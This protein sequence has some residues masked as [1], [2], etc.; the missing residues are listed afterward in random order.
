MRSSNSDRKKPF[1]QQLPLVWRMIFSYSLLV[2]IL[3]ILVLGYLLFYQLK[4]RNEQIEMQIEQL[5][6]ALAENDSII[7]GLEMNDLDSVTVSMLDTLYRNLTYVDYI[8]IVNSD[9]IRIYHSEKDRI[10][11]SFA[12]GDEGPAL[13]GDSPS[14]VTHGKGSRQ[15][16][17]RAFTTVYD[18]S[19]NPIGFVLVSTYM[20]RIQNLRSA[21]TRQFGLLFTAALILGIL[22]AVLIA[23]SIRR[24]LLGYEP[25]Q[26]SDLYVQK[27]DL[28]NALD[29]GVIAVDSAGHCIYYNQSALTLFQSPEA[30]YDFSEHEL[31]SNDSFNNRRIRFGSTDLLVSQ[32][33]IQDKKQPLGAMAILRDR[34]E[35]NELAEE[36]TGVQHIIAAL[37]ATTHEHK[38]K[39]HVI[40][41]LLQIGDNQ[42]AMDYISTTNDYNYQS[43]TQIYDRIENRTI[44]ALLCGKQNRA[45]E[46]DIA[47]TLQNDSHLDSHNDF[48]AVGDM[49][50]IIGNL[51]EN[52]FDALKDYDGIREVSVF[53]QNTSEGI[54]IIVD[55]TGPGM[56]EEYIEK[57]YSG[58][59]TTKGEGH[60]IGLSLIKNIL[61][62]NHGLLDIASAPG[63]GSSFTISV[64]EK[65]LRKDAQK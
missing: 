17:L 11:Q 15:Y 49:V 30:I 26:L 29:E 5:S 33:R 2:C 27:S 36:L 39:L 1:F 53:I 18:S 9:D 32:L 46:L 25:T 65:R 40:M 10:G 54:T 21:M 14:Y 60:G 45:R 47:F 4:D 7:N 64:N 8:V 63:E 44:A 41:G 61:N 55:D 13:S 28:L 19:G 20:S 38:N 62:Q 6:S 51:I 3:L 34:T 35:V 58:T 31:Q 59:F 52:A 23:R 12:G 16:Q 22:F 48:L 24:S 56:P 50:T 37:R 57:I 42:A 43:I